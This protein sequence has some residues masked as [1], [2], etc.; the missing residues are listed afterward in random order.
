MSTEAANLLVTK[1]LYRA[2]I[3][4]STTPCE[5]SPGVY[6][7]RGVQTGD[8]CKKWGMCKEESYHVA[9]LG[10]DSKVIKVS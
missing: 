5:I 6:Y 8:H 9:I 2:S 1:A 4:P 7:V 3:I 10:Y